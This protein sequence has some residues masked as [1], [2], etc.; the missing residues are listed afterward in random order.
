MII[1]EMKRVEMSMNPQLPLGLPAGSEIQNVAFVA[2]KKPG[3]KVLL[4]LPPAI[5]RFAI[6]VE[7][8]AASKE[9]AQ[10]ID[11]QILSIM[12][13]N[14]QDV[15]LQ[16]LARDWVVNGSIN[17]GSQLQVMTL[18][19]AQV[20]W[21]AGRVAVIAPADRLNLIRKALIEASW[22]EQE[23]RDIEQKLAAAWP[24]ME[25]DMPLAFTFDERSLNKHTQLQQRFQQIK[26]IQAR[27]ARL[28]PHVNCPHLHPPT[29]ASQVSERFRE[30][31]Q[32]IHRHEFLEEQV[33]VFEDVYDSCGQRA[34]D[35]IESRKGQMLEWVIIVLLTTQLLL[36]VFELL[37]SAAAPVTGQ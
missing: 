16:S 27:L 11:L 10:P 19:G 31:N 13:E 28:G 34:S 18:Q 26:L 15:E 2:E 14:H 12:A 4:E 33:E 20:F 29:L 3:Q 7:V 17:S 5:Q 23:L 36:W 30:R 9:N 24:Q 1:Q 25:A 8:D 35:F 6:A 32:M 22:Y 37:T 21:S